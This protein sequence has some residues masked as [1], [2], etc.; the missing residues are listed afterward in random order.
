VK[1]RNKKFS[2]KSQN[3]LNKLS[4]FQKNDNRFSKKCPFKIK[5]APKIDYK[6]IKILKNILQKMEKFFHLKLA[7]FLKVSRDC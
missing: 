2:K 3:G 1:K 4:L 6:N 5:N 7:L